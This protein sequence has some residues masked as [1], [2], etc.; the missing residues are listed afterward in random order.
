MMQP[1][2]M[3]PSAGRLEKGS[4]HKSQLNAV[5]S[6][7]ASGFFIVFIVHRLM[8]NWLMTAPAAI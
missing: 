6:D 5:E 3:Q 2:Y 1:T 8:C 7:E 4:E